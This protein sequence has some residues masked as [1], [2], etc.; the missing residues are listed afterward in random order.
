MLLALTALS[1]FAVTTAGVYLYLY[2]ATWCPYCRSLDNFFNQAYPGRYYFCKIDLYE[3]CKTNLKALNEYLVRSKGIPSEILGGIPQTLVIRD[4][5]Y[6]LAIVIG[7]ITD[8]KFW[9]EITSMTPQERVLL[10]VPPNKYEIPVTFNEQAEIVSKY[11]P[12]STTSGTS[13]G[14][15]LVVPAVLAIIGIAVI[16]YALLRRR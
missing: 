15:L 1:S 2:G 8:S 13:T 5:R 10:I 7:G 11:A 16:A 6:L 12:V 14:T 9:D 3:D 4:G